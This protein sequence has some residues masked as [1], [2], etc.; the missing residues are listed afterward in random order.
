MEFDRFCCDGLMTLPSEIYKSGQYLKNNT[1]WHIEDSAWKAELVFKML[2]RAELKPTDV[3]EVGCGA[4]SVLAELRH[5]IPLANL[6]GYDIANDVTKFW[7]AYKGLNITF[8]AGDFL[9]ENTK[10]FDVL[11]MLDV[12]EHLE[13]P[14]SFLRAIRDQADYFILH[15]PLDLSAFSVLLESPL[16]YSRHKVGHIHYFT[17]SL[18]ISLL[19]ESG[20]EIIESIYTGAAFSLLHMTWRKRLV[21]LPR[22]LA[23]MLNRDIGVRLFGGETLILLAK[24]KVEK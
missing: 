19:E 12:L 11:L 1:T 10:H 9:K 6:V 20:F 8:I 18:A 13:C 3:V 17:K 14:F 21:M 7:S 22:Y 2:K 16:I 5:K 23:Y 15:I 24:S 4:G